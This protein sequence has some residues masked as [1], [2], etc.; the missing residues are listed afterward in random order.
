M[1]MQNDELELTVVVILV[2]FQVFKTISTEIASY[3]IIQILFAISYFM[4]ICLPSFLCKHFPQQ[5]IVL[6][7]FWR[8][9]SIFSFVYPATVIFFPLNIPCL[10]QWADLYSLAYF[11]FWFVLFS[12]F[13]FW[14]RIL[15]LRATSEK[16]IL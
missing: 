12:V 3:F 9:Y 15:S 14:Y 16:D 1:L 13:V 5:E 7:M 2:K 10:L 11:V 6:Q 4:S 8:N